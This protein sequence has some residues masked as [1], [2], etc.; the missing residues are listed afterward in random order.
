LRDIAKPVGISSYVTRL[1]ETLPK[2]LQSSL[3]TVA[4]LE[5]EMKAVAETGTKRKPPKKPRS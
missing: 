5:A 3:P 1:V 2:E 4:D